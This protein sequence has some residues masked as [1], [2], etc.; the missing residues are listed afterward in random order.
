MNRS[1]ITL[2]HVSECAKAFYTYSRDAINKVVIAR[3]FKSHYKLKER[4]AVWIMKEINSYS[5][6]RLN[7]G[8]IFGNLTTA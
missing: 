1:T 5:Q 8:L 4:E 6:L 3:A 2:F 7:T